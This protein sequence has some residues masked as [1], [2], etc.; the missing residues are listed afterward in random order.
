MK[1]RKNESGDLSPLSRK[2]VIAVG[3]IAPKEL[4]TQTVRT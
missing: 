2:I 3:R 4:L 1:F